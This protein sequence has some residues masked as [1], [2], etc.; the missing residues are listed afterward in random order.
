MRPALLLLPLLLVT[1]VLSAAPRLEKQPLVLPS[2]TRIDLQLRVP[3]G[4][5][6]H[7]ALL[8]FGGFRG[9]ARVFE[10]IPA[11]V[12][13]LLASFDYPVAGERRFRFPQ[14]LLTLPA[15]ARGIDDSYAGVVRAVDALRARRDVDPHRL[16]LVGASLGAPFALYGAAERPV[17]GLV[18]IQGF[19]D[20]Q[21]TIARQF[22][23]KLVPRYGDWLRPP[24]RGLSGLLVWSFDLAPP[25]AA[26]RRLR[27][28]QH[29]LLLEARDDER[30]PPEARRALRTA[31]EASPAHLSVQAL[32]G[33]HLR[34]VDDPALPAILAQAL[35][36]MRRQGLL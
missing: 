15:L 31:I 30:L 28:A 11:D 36:W 29:V 17:P 19:G 13:V 1:S 10:T 8:L 26:A 20:L 14:S 5:G 25:E 32:P 35:A 3:E 4:Q 24:L 34:G 23:N 22:E 12:P 18:L 21:A 33:G 6:P 9:A 2:G 16:T 27:G 7:P